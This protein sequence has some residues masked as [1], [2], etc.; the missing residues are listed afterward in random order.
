[1]MMNHTKALSDP[2]VS[3]KSESANEVLEHAAATKVR[4]LVMSVNLTSIQI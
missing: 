3:R 4:A 2:V 1:M